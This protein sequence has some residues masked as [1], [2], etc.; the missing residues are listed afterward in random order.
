MKGYHVIEE[1]TSKIYRNTEIE[2]N[3]IWSMTP[4]HV[5]DRTLIVKGEMFLES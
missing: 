3:A 5:L 1:D 4:N 2:E